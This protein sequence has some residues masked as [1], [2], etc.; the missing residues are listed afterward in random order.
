M[1]W[2]CT[3]LTDYEINQIFSDGLQ[4]PTK[5]FFI[6]KIKNLPNSVRKSTKKTF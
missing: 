6:E 4:F 1:C 3:R 2:H 5:E